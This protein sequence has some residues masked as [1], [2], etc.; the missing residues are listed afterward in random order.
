MPSG[1]MPYRPVAGLRGGLLAA[2]LTAM[3]VR[4]S[5]A[6]GAAI[7]ANPDGF[8]EHP[9]TIIVPYA[10]G[11]ESDQ[12]ARALAK[13]LEKVTG[14]GV[15]V[16]NKPGDTGLTAIPDF[17]AAPADGYTILEAID[18]AVANYV[19]GRLTDNPAVDW[20]PLGL[21]QISFSQ[22]Y[23]RPGDVRFSD[24]AT[25][26][27]YGRASPGDLKIANVGNPGAMERVNMFKVEQALGLKTNQVALDNPVERYAALIG[28]SV[29]AL[30]EQPGDVVTFLDSGKMTP[31]LTLHSERPAAFASVP[32]LADI[33][34]RF[35]PL[36][37]FRGF[38]VLPGV[39]EPRRK[40]LEAAVR[41]AWQSAEFQEFNRQRSMTFVP[42]YLDHKGA[43]AL[44]TKEIETYKAA[45]REIGLGP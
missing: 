2:I 38:W 28:G 10:A 39:P 40:Y 45:Y 36:L 5:A 42:S 34:V 33:G 32:T 16:M 41:A 3:L 29:D 21:T 22:I 11:G 23:I 14:V 35:D 30:F 7:P 1:T 37:R 9:L 20:W 15:L 17:A 13:S 24:W 19:G 25:F 27:A 8:P 26:V 44:I 43:K 6:L 31:I 4:L 12:M 18:D